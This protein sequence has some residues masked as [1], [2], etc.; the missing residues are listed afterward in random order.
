MP[1]QLLGG[2]AN[3]PDQ[4]DG[5]A[6]TWA[7]ASISHKVRVDLSVCVWMCLWSIH[8]RCSQFHTMC[9]SRS[10]CICVNVFVIHTCA[11]F[12]ISHKV[13]EQIWVY[14]WMYLWSIRVRCSQFHTRCESRSEC[15]RVILFVIHTCA[16]FMLEMHNAWLMRGMQLCYLTV[17]S[18][19]K[20]VMYI[21][22]VHVCGWGIWGCICAQL[23]HV[24]I[25]AHN[26]FGVCVCVCVCVFKSCHALCRD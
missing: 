10:E 9:V 6:P 18:S 11:L 19:F 21:L 24:S 26:R 12:S 4:Q 22:F 17:V 13:W 2:A 25:F 7:T 8:V 1:L 15:M 5:S 14:V 20:C 23:L 16:L 3:D